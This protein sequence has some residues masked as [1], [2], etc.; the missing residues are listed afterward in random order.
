MKKI[1]I[2]DIAK[3]L[4]VSTTTISYILNGKAREKHI[5]VEVEKKVEEYA[6]KHNYRPNQLAKG[7]RM[8]KT[9]LIC[10]M[11]EDIGD[12]Y[13]SEVAR[14]IESIAYE[15]GY[16]IVYCNTKN[17]LEKTQELIDTFRNI[18]VDGYI[19]APAGNIEKDILELIDDKIPVVTFDRNAEGLN[20]SY[21]GT[22]N[23]ESSYK[24]TKHLLEQGFE[25][26][27]FITLESQQTHMQNRLLGYEKAIEESSKQCYIKK[28]DYAQKTEGEVI[29]EIVNFLKD[30]SSLDAVYFSTNYLAIDG[31]GA[32]NKLG[33]RLIDDIGMLVFDDIALFRVYQPTITAIAQPIAEM[34]QHIINLMLSHLVDTKNYIPEKTTVPSNLQIRESSI[35]KLKKK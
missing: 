35:K 13:F 23:F 8:G 31:L 25:K 1:S 15:K 7:L 16:R 2:K 30:N 27:A 17:S 6:K 22:D 14:D 28:V 32:F 20:V 3:A 10:L 18:N 26:I 9:H 21:V 33:L 4:N 12:L 34:S 24:G 19:I 5:S 29:N 11:I